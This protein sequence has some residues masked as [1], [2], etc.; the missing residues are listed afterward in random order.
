MEVKALMYL[1]PTTG[2]I[3]T[4]RYIS[5]NFSECSCNAINPVDGHQ[6]LCVILTILKLNE[7]EKTLKDWPSGKCWFDF[8]VLYCSLGL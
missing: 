6:L 7:N 1:Y 8:F 3:N 2:G 4:T 5:C